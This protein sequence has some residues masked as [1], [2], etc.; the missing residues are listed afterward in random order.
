LGIDVVSY[1]SAATGERAGY[2]DSGKIGTFHL[3][4]VGVKQL[5]MR[6]VD[7]LGAQDRGFDQLY[8]VVC[9]QS[10]IGALQKIEI[11]YALVVKIVPC[12]TVAHGQRVVLAELIIDARAD[13]KAV[14]G[15]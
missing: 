12:V 15:G 3:S 6:L 5:E 13:A 10:M 14:L 7:H 1:L 4:R 11:A 8:G 9:V 2:G